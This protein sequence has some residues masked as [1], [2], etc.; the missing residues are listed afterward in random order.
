MHINNY[1]RTYVS[2]SIKP[3]YSKQVSFIISNAIVLQLDCRFRLQHK[4][5]NTTNIVKIARNPIIPK[6]R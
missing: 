4:L 2:T 1:L 3:S 6:V 5:Q